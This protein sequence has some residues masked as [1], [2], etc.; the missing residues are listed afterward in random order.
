MRPSQTYHLVGEHKDC[1]ETK[2]ALA[3]VEKILEAR[4]EQVDHH[5]VVV[6]LNSKPVHV[7]DT[8]YSAKNG[9]KVSEPVFFD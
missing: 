2:L 7:W 3:V 5:D 8:N 6:A 1:F 9:K 4:A